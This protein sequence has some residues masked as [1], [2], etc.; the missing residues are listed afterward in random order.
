[1][2]CKILIDNDFFYFSVWIHRGCH[3][4]EKITDASL[5]GLISEGKAY[6]EKGDLSNAGTKILA[7]Y[8]N[9]IKDKSSLNT[10]V[11]KDLSEAL[12]KVGDAVLK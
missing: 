12:F 2:P 5:T 7:A 10:A 3:G 1:M 4:Q 9:A 8:E 6:L 11:S